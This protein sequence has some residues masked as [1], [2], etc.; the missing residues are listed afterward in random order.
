[1]KSSLIVVGSALAHTDTYSTTYFTS[2]WTRDPCLLDNVIGDAQSPET[3]HF[4]SSVLLVKSLTTVPAFKTQKQKSQQNR[5]A[6]NYSVYDMKN[7]V[8]Q[9]SMRNVQHN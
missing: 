5:T 6:V 9:Y 1:M 3:H 8:H 2:T 7:K 4:L